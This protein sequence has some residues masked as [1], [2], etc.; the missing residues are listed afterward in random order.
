M[1]V[2]LNFVINCIEAEVIYK[3]VFLS[4]VERCDS[5]TQIYP[6]FHHGFITGC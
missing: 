6:L 5:V 2:L 1:S 4:S 3:V